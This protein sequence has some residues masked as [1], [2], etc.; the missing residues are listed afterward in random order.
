MMAIDKFASLAGCREDAEGRVFRKNL[1]LAVAFL[2]PI[3]STGCQTTTTPEET[4]KTFDVSAASK[5]EEMVVKT[6]FRRTADTNQKFNVHLELGR[7][8]ESEGNFDA[9]VNEY[10]KSIDACKRGGP[11]AGGIKIPKEQ[12]AESHRRMAG[13]LDRLG[14]FVQA[15][16]HYRSALELSPNDPKVWNDSGYSYYLQA[17]HADAERNLKTAAKLDPNNPRVQTNL[18]LAMAAAGKTDEALAALSKAGG[19]AAGNANLAYLLASLGK[20]EEARKHYHAALRLQPEM[21]PARE[22]LARL[23]A[24]DVQDARSTQLAAIRTRGAAT[25]DSSIQRVATPAGVAPESTKPAVVPNAHRPHH[26]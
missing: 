3:A 15:E 26:H 20:T 16:A 9:A 7:A 10:Q 19:P 25:T 4:K 24:K 17:R 18:G 2:V 14:R 6:D 1:A 21:A 23:D 5:S 13:A 8:Y 11:F 12:E 22:A